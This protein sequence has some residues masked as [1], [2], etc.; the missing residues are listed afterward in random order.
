[1]LKCNPS[2]GITAAA[3]MELYRTEFLEQ[4]GCS[5]FASL[6]GRMPVAGVW[7]TDLVS[8]TLT[9][10]CGASWCI[11]SSSLS[12]V[13]IPGPP[14]LPALPACLPEQIDTHHAMVLRDMDLAGQ[15][16]IADRDG[17]GR[18]NVVRSLAKQHD[19]VSFPRPQHSK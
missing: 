16:R 18:L 19:M 15:F 2:L 8:G 6:A 12:L 5:F 11:F 9:Q 1:M 14:C 13:V 17:D 10:C 4:V 7:L 3:L